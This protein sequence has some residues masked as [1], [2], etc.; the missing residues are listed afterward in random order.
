MYES[1]GTVLLTPNPAL[2]RGRN[3]YFDLDGIRKI[4]I[5][6]M[7]RELFITLCK[8]NSILQSPNHSSHYQNK[9]F[10]ILLTLI[11]HVV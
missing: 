7:S 5:N 8:K 1:K 9:F 10:K 4:L 2:F 3:V 11:L 6:V